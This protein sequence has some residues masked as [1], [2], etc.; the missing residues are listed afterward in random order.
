MQNGR[1]P[2]YMR[3]KKFS[4]KGGESIVGTMAS[5]RSRLGYGAASFEEMELQ[6]SRRLNEKGKIGGCRVF[7]SALEKGKEKMKYRLREESGEGHKKKRVLY[8]E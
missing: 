8:D 3:I 2:A 6:W 4:L 1:E 5:E 7:W